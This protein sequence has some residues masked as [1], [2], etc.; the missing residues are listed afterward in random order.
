M[1]SNLPKAKPVVLP[2][3]PDPRD[4]AYVQKPKKGVCINVPIHLYPLYMEKYSLKPNGVIEPS[5][6]VKVKKI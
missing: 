1:K 3:P 4:L 6:V 5:G 2:E